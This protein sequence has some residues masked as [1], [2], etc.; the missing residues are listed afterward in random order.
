MFLWKIGSRPC[1]HPG[2]ISPKHPNHQSIGPA[3]FSSS[4]ISSVKTCGVWWIP[5]NPAHL[6]ISPPYTPPPYG[7]P[8]PKINSPTKPGVIL[9]GVHYCGKCLAGFRP[10]SET[11]I[12]SVWPIISISSWMTGIHFTS[13]LSFH[14]CAK[15][16]LALTAKLPQLSQQ[17]AVHER[18]WKLQS[19]ID[20][21]AMFSVLRTI[22]GQQS[23]FGLLRYAHPTET[24]G[25]AAP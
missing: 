20:G 22:C 24:C 13:Q 8:N 1:L 15:C 9:A 19:E 4:C 7:N 18:E 21:I 2:D 10:T 11:Y 12:F 25:L 3:A 23:A 16:S 17:K 14:T 5:E 6:T